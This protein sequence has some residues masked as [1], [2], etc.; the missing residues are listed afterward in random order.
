MYYNLSWMRGT[1]DNTAT[2]KPCNTVYTQ[3]YLGTPTAMNE[4]AEFYMAGSPSS[5]R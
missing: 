5:K 2:L 3:R 4:V 1:N